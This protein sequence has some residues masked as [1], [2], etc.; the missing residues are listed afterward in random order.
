[1]LKKMELSIRSYAECSAIAE[2]SAWA[3]NWVDDAQELIATN[4]ASAPIDRGLYGGS[5]KS[6]PTQA[7]DSNGG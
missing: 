6:E 7:Q 2:T 3:R 5:E 4:P 1:M